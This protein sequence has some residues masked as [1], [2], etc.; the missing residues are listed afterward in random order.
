MI[1]KN[2]P[3]LIFSDLDGT[4]LDH[5]T[6]SFHEAREALLG[7]KNKGIPLILCSSKTRAEMEGLRRE[8]DNHDPFITENGAAVF[9]PQGLFGPLDLK[10]K[11]VEGYEV[12]E[13]GIP[14]DKIKAL[15]RAIKAETGLPAKGFS[16]MSPEQIARFTGLDLEKAAL[17]GQREYSEPFLLT[18]EMS[19]NQRLLIEQAVQKKNLTLVRGGRFYHLTGP[20]DKGKAV[21]LLI[22]LYQKLNRSIVSIGLGDSPNDFPMLENVDLPI[23]IKKKTGHLEPWPGLTPVYHSRE[24]GPKGWNEFVN[25]FLKEAGHE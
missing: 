24:V 12:V 6:Y 8:L 9:I 18:E 25:Y 23:L 5:D 15:F 17:A 19:G 14:Y 13:L 1:K 22:N 7:L 20:N 4:L 2:L 3:Y 11:A 10:Y 21:R 16:E